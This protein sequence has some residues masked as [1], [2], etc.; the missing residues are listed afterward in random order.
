MVYLSPYEIDIL[1]TK[2]YGSISW[3]TK[4]ESLESIDI[5]QKFSMINPFVMSDSSEPMLPMLK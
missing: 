4:L 1:S 3:N 5:F 2:E